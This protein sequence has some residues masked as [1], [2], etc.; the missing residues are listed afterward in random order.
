[1]LTA[2]AAQ[3]DPLNAFKGRNRGIFLAFEGGETGGEFIVFGFPLFFRKRHHRRSGFIFSGV[4][5][6]EF[7]RLAGLRRWASRGVVIGQR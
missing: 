1:M 6:Y 3:H 7:I 2:P 4:G 5:G